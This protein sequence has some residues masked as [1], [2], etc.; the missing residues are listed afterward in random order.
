MKKILLINPKLGQAKFTFNEPLVLGVLAALTPDNYEIE[1]LDENFEKFHYIPCDLVAITGSTAQIN[2]AYYISG[3]Y[4]KQ[5]IPSIIGGIHASFMPDEAEQYCTS[6]VVG[7]SESVWKDVLHDFENNSLKKRYGNV[8]KYKRVIVAPRREIFKKYPYG[9]ASIETSRGCHQVCEYCSVASLY[10]YKH[11][12]RPVEDILEDIKTIDNGVIFFTDDNFIGDYNNKERVVTILNAMIQH[13]KKW[14]GFVCMDI[15][16]HPDLLELFQKSGCILLFIGVETD[17]ADTLSAIKKPINLKVFNKDKLADCARIIHSYHIP[18]MG[19]QIF[20]FDTDTSIKDM[21]T[22]LKRIDKSGWDWIV[23]FLL[24][25][26]PGSRMFHRLRDE[27]RIMF[28]NY[29]KDW[30]LYNY[31]NSLFTHKDYDMEE[32]NVFF[33]ETHHSYYNRRN[34]LRRFF[35]TWRQTRS[36]KQ[37][38]YL[39][40]WVINN[41]A[42]IQNYW[43]IKVLMFLVKHLRLLR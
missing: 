9:C 22:R 31:C 40:I 1:M 15:V 29:P 19:F 30:E 24:T 6:V 25:P 38:I 27:N 16:D 4:N 18:I 20:G 36:L 37:T 26:I 7:D 17:E 28:K 42:N 43:F 3:E 10:K 32:L 5:G 21:H 12:E 11:F 13:K 39:Y 14:A 2:R 8:D 41:W 34:T 33:R 23:I 35:R